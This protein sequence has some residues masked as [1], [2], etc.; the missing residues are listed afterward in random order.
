MPITLQIFQYSH[1]GGISKSYMPILMV[2][3]LGKHK[4]D[5]LSARLSCVEFLFLCLYLLPSLWTIWSL[6]H[7]LVTLNLL[8][9]WIAEESFYSLIL[10][11]PASEC[12][13]SVFLINHLITLL[14]PM[15]SFTIDVVVVWWH[16]TRWH[17]P[18]NYTEFF[19]FQRTAVTAAATAFFTVSVM[20]R[21]IF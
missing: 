19:F 18:S 2:L 5:R 3:C 7:Q 11:M 14:L 20:I 1:S 9:N 21:L 6:F 13:N 4:I 16:S 8:I 12:V 17:V 10:A 15:C